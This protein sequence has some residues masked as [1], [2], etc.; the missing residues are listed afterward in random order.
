MFI[1]IT[2]SSSV[3]ALCFL[4]IGIISAKQ[5]LLKDSNTYP[6]SSII[7]YEILNEHRQKSNCEFVAYGLFI[8]IN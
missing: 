6:F 2:V 7:K 4:Y 3:R 1:R 8:V 5:T